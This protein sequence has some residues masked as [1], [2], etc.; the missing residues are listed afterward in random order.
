[1]ETKEPIENGID[2]T[3]RERENFLS[4]CVNN[5]LDDIYFGVESISHQV[6][7]PIHGIT[8]EEF[9]TLVKELDSENFTSLNPIYGF[10][11]ALFETADFAMRLDKSNI[12]EDLLKKLDAFD[13]SQAVE[14]EYRIYVWQSMKRI[15]VDYVNQL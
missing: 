11:D 7:A 15:I 13:K 8:Y 2:E 9:K 1:M 10:K 3:I 4:D 5:F 6:F 14:V 12:T